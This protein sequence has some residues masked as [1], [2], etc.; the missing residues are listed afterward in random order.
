VA[1]A[2]EAKMKIKMQEIEFEG[3]LEEWFELFKSHNYKNP[4]PELFKIK[5]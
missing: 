1:N 5:L 4:P 2:K 3:T